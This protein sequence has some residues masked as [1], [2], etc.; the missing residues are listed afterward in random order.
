M[1]AVRGTF[2]EHFARVISKPAMLHLGSFFKFLSKNKLY[3]AINIFG[4][5]IS[6]MFVIIIADYATRQLTTDNF[7]DNADR[8]FVL[9]NENFMGASYKL[10][11]DLVAEYPEIETICGYA[12]LE[13]S[14]DQEGIKS[15][16]LTA[17][18]D[19]NFFDV[20]SFKLIEGDRHSALVSRNSVVVTESYAYKAWGTT[21]GVIG[22]DVTF[23][24]E[25]SENAVVSRVVTAVV[26]DMKNTLFPAEIGLFINL[27][28]IVAYNDG[29][30]KNDYS[31][32]AGNIP[33]IL[34]KEN[35]DLQSKVEDML[36]FFQDFYWIYRDGA[37]KQ[38]TLT[39]LT[40]VSFSTLGA[41]EAINKSSWSFVIILLSVGILIL[42]F[43]VMNYINLTV[44]QTSMRAKEMATRRLLG[45]T[46]TEIVYRYIGESVLLCT[47]SFLIAFCL[48]AMAEPYA[49]SLLQSPLSVVHDLSLTRV[50]SYGALVLV[51]G[52]VSGVIPAMVVSRYQPIDVVKGSFKLRTKMVFSKV[53]LVFQNVITV[54]LIA[55]SIIMSQQIK[56]MIN[57]PLGYNYENIIDIGA[58]EGFSSY[59]QISAFKKEALQLA[60]V[61]RVGLASA[62]PLEGG[63]N[64]TL[65]LGNDKMI[66]FQILYGDP[67]Y[68]SM[69]GFEMLADNHLAGRGMSINEEALR[70]MD[71]TT[72]AQE[73]RTG[74]NFE[75]RTPIASVYKDFQVRSVLG[76]KYAVMMKE[77]PDYDMVVEHPGAMV[78][79]GPFTIL[80]EVEGDHKEAFEQL[81]ALHDRISDGDIFDAEFIEDQIEEG[82]AKE[83]NLLS[84]IQIFTLI[85]I[86]ISAL[87]QLAMSSFFI[88]QRS[89]EIAVRKVFGSSDSQILRKLILTSTYSV[90]V[91]FVISIP[92]VCFA[93]S[94]W[95][96]SYIYKISISPLVFVGAGLFALVIAVVTVF[97]LSLKASRS[98]PAEAV[99]S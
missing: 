57:A 96:K 87:G 48:A 65:P 46:Q 73:F 82:F 64:R 67:A 19:S 33:F 9:G 29:V 8:I 26:E 30:N 83:R 70:Q 74:K 76:V 10:S 25:G 21:Q 6:L 34:V 90:L 43:A 99:Q 20:F 49:V 24:A 56:H 89:L 72:N 51:V 86:L 17:F 54:A 36:D 98:N 28:N 61:K 75:N 94:S 7:H 97:W 14:I 77:I 88:R 11:D 1:V 53:F 41:F 18:V 52:I 85:A 59:T 38:V 63:N 23:A 27:G 4:F 40:D 15:Q 78:E 60:C 39:P 62:T 13:P 32:A 71:L 95:L 12:T 92:I 31:N 44:A 55:S 47:L 81:A 91:A 2:F 84:I 3:T 22:K 37:M 68:F 93:M 50:L 66:S 35:A 80:V 16:V 69:M 42:F 5:A 79:F 45:A 58:G